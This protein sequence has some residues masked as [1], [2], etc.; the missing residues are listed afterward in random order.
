MAP[1]QH[2]Q[3]QRRS[4]R[5]QQHHDAIFVALGLSHD[6]NVAIKVHV[7]DAKANALHQA[8]TGAV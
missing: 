1:R 5:A 6:D 8:D 4:Q 2:L 3:A 7:L